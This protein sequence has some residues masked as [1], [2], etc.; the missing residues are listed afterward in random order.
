MAACGNA[1]CNRAST[2]KACTAL[3]G[4]EVDVWQANDA[5]GYDNAGFTLRGVF[6]SDASGKFRIET[7]LPGRY[8]DGASYR[9][10]HIHVIVRAQGRAEL[11]T[12]LYF[13]GDPYNATD[14]LFQESLMMSPAS[15]GAGGQASSFDFVLA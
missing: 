1:C 3:S 15:D 12:Q 5:G 13:E 11:T 4:A 6:V 8:L 2:G 7:I 9:P 14:S 10:R